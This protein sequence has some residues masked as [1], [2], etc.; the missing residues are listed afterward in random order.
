MVSKRWLL[1]LLSD[2][3]GSAEMT[4]KVPCSSDSL[5]LY[6]FV[7]KKNV[8]SDLQDVWLT[9]AWEIRLKFTWEL[10]PSDD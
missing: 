5:S 1:S 8:V 3:L 2:A 6:G 4:S 7:K 10:R 9:G